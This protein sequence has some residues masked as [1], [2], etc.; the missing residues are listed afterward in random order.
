MDGIILLK[1]NLSLPIGT[2]LTRPVRPNSRDSLLSIKENSLRL[3]HD[4]LSIS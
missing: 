2:V 4:Q 1:L 3:L